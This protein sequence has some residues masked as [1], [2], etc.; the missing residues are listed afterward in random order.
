MEKSKSFPQYSSF[1]S[2]EFGFEDQS[3]SYNFNGPSQKG[4]GF[5]TSSDPELK[6]KKRIASYNVFTVEGKLKSSARNSF[7]WTHQHIDRVI[8]KKKNFHQQQHREPPHSI[9]RTLPS[10]VTPRRL[11][12]PTAPRRPS[13]CTTRRSPRTR[14]SSRHRRRVAVK[15]V[16]WLELW[17]HCAVAVPA[18]V[19]KIAASAYAHASQ[20]T[21]TPREDKG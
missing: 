5:A 19:S 2:G 18:S 8:A 15:R 11:P 10:K 16:S 17:P 7:K 1:F 9:C 20:S 21:A 4:N 14:P 6:R 3:N 13:Q 12:R